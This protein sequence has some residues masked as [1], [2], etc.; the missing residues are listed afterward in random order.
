MFVVLE[1]MEISS[2]MYVYFLTPIVMQKCTRRT[3]NRYHTESG[4]RET[5]NLK[6]ILV[7]YSQGTATE[8]TVSC[9][10]QGVQIFKSERCVATI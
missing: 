5:W 1:G 6:D 10:Q 7:E 3:S 8:R 9:Q 4:N 2:E